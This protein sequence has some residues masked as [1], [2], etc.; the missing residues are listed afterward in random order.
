VTHGLKTRIPE[1]TAHLCIDMQR[2]FV[3]GTEWHTPWAAKTLPAIEALCSARPERLWFTRFIPAATPDE[4]GGAWR[5]YWRRWSTMTKNAFDP[6]MLDLA[7][8]LQRFA[9]PAQIIDKTVYSAWSGTHLHKAFKDQGV[10]TLVVTGAETDVCVL[11]TVLGAIDLGYRIVVVSDG[12]CSSA[13]QPH[14]HLLALYSDRFSLQV[15]TAECREVL[16]AWV[17]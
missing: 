3:E 11:S 6:A 15:E 8:P 10:D 2:M 14:D 17:A 13:D 5:D 7:L 16:E 12:V 9:P 1:T 4:A